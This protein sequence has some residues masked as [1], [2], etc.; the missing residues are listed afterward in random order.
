MVAAIR[1]EQ[2][3]TKERMRGSSALKVIGE[4]HLFGPDQNG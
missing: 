1:L 4:G 2:L 3:R